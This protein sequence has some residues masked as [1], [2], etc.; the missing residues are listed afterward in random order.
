MVDAL[1]HGPRRRPGPGDVRAQA[2]DEAP[3]R[4]AVAELVVENNQWFDVHLYLVRGSL[5]TSLGFL[6]SLGRRKFE[7]PS[8]ATTPGTDV[9]IFVYPIAGGRPY[10]TPPLIVNPGDVWK[11]VVENNPALSRVWVLPTA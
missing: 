10:L 9:R 5:R 6:T 3:A 7:L 8:I 4:D 11:L 2:T 1:A